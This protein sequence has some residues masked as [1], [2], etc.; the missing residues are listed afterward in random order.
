M[1]FVILLVWPCWDSIYCFDFLYPISDL[2]TVL[3]QYCILTGRWKKHLMEFSNLGFLNSVMLTWLV[4]NVVRFQWDVHFQTF[5]LSLSLFL[6]LTY[7]C[8]RRLQSLF[9]T[10][11]WVW[12]NLPRTKPSS[13]SSQHYWPLATSSIAP[14]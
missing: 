5:F 6:S 9:L 12:N 13:I 7:E 4:I 14:M 2:F 8:C 10:S 3:F 1:S 11:N